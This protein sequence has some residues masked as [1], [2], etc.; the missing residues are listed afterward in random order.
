MPILTISTK[1]F[2]RDLPQATTFLAPHKLTEFQYGMTPRKDL[3]KGEHIRVSLVLTL[4]DKV[5]KSIF[6]LFEDNVSPR[7]SVCLSRSIFHNPVTN[8]NLHNVLTHNVVR[9]MFERFELVIEDLEEKVKKKFEESNFT[10]YI[11]TKRLDNSLPALTVGLTLAV[12]K[13]EINKSSFFN[14]ENHSWLDFDILN[15]LR[16]KIQ[17]DDDSL[18]FMAA[19]TSMLQPNEIL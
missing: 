9:E 3:V 5:S 13:A 8:A 16:Q 18:V 7:M 12:D 14:S 11:D 2:K 17:M 19:L 4:F 6:T 15:D 10:L 1:P